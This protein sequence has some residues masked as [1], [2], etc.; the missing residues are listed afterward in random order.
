ML[1]FSES[2]YFYSLTPSPS[3][4]QEENTSGDQGDLGWLEIPKDVICSSGKACVDETDK[5]GAIVSRQETAES[6]MGFQLLLSR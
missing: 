6:D 4:H 5:N 2:E 3:D 1:P